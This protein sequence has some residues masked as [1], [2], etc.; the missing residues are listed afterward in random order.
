M[1]HIIRGVLA[2]GFV[3][4]VAGCSNQQEEVVYVE[5]PVIIEPVS[6]KY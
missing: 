4:I 3:A 1:S 2:L 5:E 6:N